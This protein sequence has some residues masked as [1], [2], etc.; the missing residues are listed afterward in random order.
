MDLKDFL[1]LGDSKDE[2][3]SSTNEIFERGADIVMELS[4]EM[5]KEITNRLD[6]EKSIPGNLKIAMVIGTE[7]AMLGSS[8]CAAASAYKNPK[9]AKELMKRSFDTVELMVSDYLKKN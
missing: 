4:G 8:I 1:G 3:T 7:S 2:K 6:K 5:C 9:S